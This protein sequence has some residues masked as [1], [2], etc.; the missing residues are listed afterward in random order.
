M[1][2]LLQLIVNS[3]NEMKKLGNALS[4]LFR[5]KDVVCFKGELGAGKTFLCREIINCMTKIEEVPSP[6]FNLVQT[7]PLSKINNNEIWHC[8]FFRLNSYEEVIEIGVFDELKK[9]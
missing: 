7:Y 5:V 3:E 2:T 4:G 6:T 8:D 1:E 9:K